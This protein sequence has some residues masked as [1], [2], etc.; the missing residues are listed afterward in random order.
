MLALALVLAAAAPA[1]VKIDQKLVGGWYAADVAYLNL[2][3]DGTGT[4]DKVKVKWK[5][6][7]EALTLDDGT[8][9]PDVG[10]YRLD[11]DRLVITLG[12]LPIELSKT[13]GASAP[14]TKAAKR[15]PL[16]K[17][18]KSLAYLKA[19][20]FSPGEYLSADGFGQILGANPWCSA[21]RR[22]EFDSGGG[23][24][25]DGERGGRWV[26]RRGKMFMGDGMNP[27][28]LVNDFAMNLGSGMGMSLH[29]NGT[30]FD[31]CN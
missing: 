28:K 11:G 23:W 25:A 4:L 7:D 17:D 5:V 24:S 22:I 14:K 16:T 13:R 30:D 20:G 2:K 12:G 19:H 8:N 6:E 9:K 21:D 27:L 18:E 26:V 29:L 3:A 10:G 31:V 15:R 1:P